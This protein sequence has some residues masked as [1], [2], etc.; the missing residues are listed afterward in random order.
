MARIAKHA[1]LALIF[2][3][4]FASAT[5]YNLTISINSGAE[6]TSAREVGLTLFAD[7][8]SASTNCSLANTNAT[9]TIFAYS[10]PAS[11]NLSSGDG[12][13]TVF[14]KC[15]DDGENWSDVASDSI[16]LD[17]IA[18]SIGSLSPANGSIITSTTPT[19]SAAISDSG[20]GV[21]TS[22][23]VM[24]VDGANISAVYSSGTLS[25][26]ASLSEGTHNVSVFAL[27]NS[28][29][30]SSV[31]WN[32]TIDKYPE[33]GDVSP[34]NNSF[35]KSTSQ[36]VYALV[37]DSGTGIN[38]TRSYLRIDGNS[39]NTTCASGRLEYSATFSEA[40]HTVEAIEYDNSG[41][42]ITKTWYFTIDKTEP[43]FGYVS[44]A[45]K[46][47]VSS[48]AVTVTAS[49]NDY[50]S[51]IKA[52]SIVFKI[53]GVA[54]TSG[55][56]YS[57]GLIS[58]SAT[59]KGGAHNAEI[60]VDDYAGNSGYKYWT[61][62]VTTK[63]PTMDT[64]APADNGFVNN[65]KPTIS[66]RIVDGGSSGIQNSSIKIFVD[67]TEYTYKATYDGVKRIITYSPTTD[68]TEG[69]HTAKVQA[70]DNIGNSGSKEWSFTIDKTAP[71]AVNGLSIAMNGTKATI[72]W[73]PV[74][75]ASKY[76]VYRSTSAIGSIS[77]LV[78]SANVNTTKYTDNLAS[79]KLYYAV[80]ALD[81]AGNE[82]APGFVGSCAKYS[83]GW[84]DYACCSDVDCSNG[85][86]C[87]SST[88]IC[89]K[90]VKIFTKAEAQDA[91]DSAKAAIFDA[92]TDGKDINES[93]ALIDQADSAMA[94]GNYSA[95]VDFS[96]S[97]KL[98]LSL[99]NTQNQT[100][101]NDTNITN[102]TT[103]PG[104]KKPFPGCSSSTAMIL[105]TVISLGIYYGVGRK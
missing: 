57:N 50:V 31:S 94:T 82:G 12:N 90:Q 22:G 9:G 26:P 14:F 78:A 55:A 6:Y 74:T 76:K 66:A 42:S 15:T 60:F 89:V 80:T 43:S 27:D 64:L 99:G 81:S 100:N 54:V 79:G 36:T 98:A 68:L 88:H 95:V 48:P 75:G 52:T 105:L 77:S 39:V 24:S 104:K 4:A 18:P 91:L 67:G 101:S 16:V 47:T 49:I 46:S 7:N 40:K 35:L 102:Q 65:S 92:L 11:W 93:Q 1:F 84:T 61:F 32:F 19:I 20:S 103:V 71:G 69:K 59:M 51:G 23:L 17:T 56:N 85:T 38:C 62:S 83:N 41:N 72:S 45:D 63:E 53:D 10:S 58:F 44:P 87:D 30:S 5:P 34:S 86:K 28:G 37:S 3:I 21:N 2:I 73:T 97:A 13:K 25:F 29:N 33:I 8:T 70:M 96:N